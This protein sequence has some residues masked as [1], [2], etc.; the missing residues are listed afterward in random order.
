MR[1]LGVI[2]ARAG[3]KGIPGK[4]IRL[5]AGLPL[6]VYAIRAGRESGIVD[7][8]VLS[9]DSV[10]IA[11]VA[12]EYGVEVPTL[13]PSHLALD[14]TPMLPVV[15]HAVAEFEAASDWRPD[16]VMLLQPTA[17]LR[18]PE[19]LRLALDLLENEQCDSVAS[20]V[21]I[22]RHYAPDFA[23]RVDEDGR[24]L[25]F[26]TEGGRVTRRQDVRPAYSRDG[27]IYAV[28]R[29][30]LMEDQTLYG[31]VCLPLILDHADSVNL[32]D[33]GDWQEAERR[34][35]RSRDSA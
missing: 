33:L 30:V 32:D 17:P 7:E 28:R 14:E 31:K 2:P 22:P 23:M 24:L 8:L 27:T 10:D 15:M 9:T 20:V 29:D 21:E 12:V 35:S 16:V 4:N 34:L 13:R 6:I 1:V 18:K 3:S 11:R 26:L 25:H 19:H 5:L